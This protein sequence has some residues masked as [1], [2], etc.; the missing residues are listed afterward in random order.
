M[1][2]RGPSLCALEAV[3]V[4]CGGASMTTLGGAGTLRMRESEN[5]Q[6]PRL[7]SCALLTEGDDPRVQLHRA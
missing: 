7:S 2:Q 1:L 4:I 3:R 5:T 6:S